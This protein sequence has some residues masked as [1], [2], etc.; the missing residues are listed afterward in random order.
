MATDTLHR[1]IR[2]LA[3]SEKRHF[4]LFA[5]LHTGDK[6]YLRLFDA[7]DR[8]EEYDEA[9]IKIKFQHER[10]IKQLSRVKNYLY[11]MI[12]KSMSAYHRQDKSTDLQLAHTLTE[13]LACNTSFWL[14]RQ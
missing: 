7:I 9:R 6:N 5:S 1:L 11:S 3:K 2:S 13:A 10:F 14:P 12:L 8:Q 4:K